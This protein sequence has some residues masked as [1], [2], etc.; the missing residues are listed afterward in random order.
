MP[1]RRSTNKVTPPAFSSTSIVN[2]TSIPGTACSNPIGATFRLPAELTCN[3]IAEACVGERLPELRASA[4]M[5]CDFI[6]ARSPA[7]E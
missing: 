4:A 6:V 1:C 7:S 3:A 5:P 2:I